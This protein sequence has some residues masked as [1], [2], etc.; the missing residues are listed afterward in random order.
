MSDKILVLVLEIR[1]NTKGGNLKAF[2]D[3]KIGEIVIKDF[4]IVQQ[5]GQKA[6]VSVPQL[7]YQS[8]AGE[9]YYKP[10]VTLPDELKERVSFEVLRKWAG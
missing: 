9:T 4:R 8:E 2:A 10:M 6:W 3:V 1:E 7:S 5:K